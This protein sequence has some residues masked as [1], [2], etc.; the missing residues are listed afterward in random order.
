MRWL[1]RRT[2]TVSV[3]LVFL[4]FAVR[5]VGSFRKN[6]AA[7]I[8]ELDA[9]QVAQSCWHH[10]CPGRTSFTEA[11]ALVYA[12]TNRVSNIYF[13]K[14]PQSATSLCWN[15]TVLLNA[16]ICANQSDPDSDII[17]YIQ[18]GPLGDDFPV[19]LGDMIALLGTPNTSNL[20]MSRWTVENNRLVAG[21][22]TA[23]SD[24]RVV[25]ESYTPKNLLS[26]RVDSAQTVSYIAFYYSPIQ[27]PYGATWDWRG[28][29]LGPEDAIVCNG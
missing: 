14:Y 13:H 28:F 29:V 25:V 21:V 5:W 18:I 11:K 27:F 9:G 1:V 10:I 19:S 6:P 8:L 4:L 20:C 15:D 23:F 26:W 12:E 17:D 16:T 2:I 22:I 3:I 7:E 24:G